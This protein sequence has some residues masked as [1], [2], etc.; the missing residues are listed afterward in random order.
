M[1]KESEKIHPLIVNIKTLIADSKQQV[2]VAVNATMSMLYWQIGKRIKE[3]IEGKNRREMY[4]KEI[5]ATLWRQSLF[6]PL[7]PCA[8]DSPFF[9]R[10]IAWKI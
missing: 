9:S 5:V 4:G 1:S 3:E 10:I 8:Y 2:A 6:K 7:K